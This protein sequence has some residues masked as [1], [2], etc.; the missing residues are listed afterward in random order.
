MGA[1]TGTPCTHEECRYL[2]GHGSPVCFCGGVWHAVASNWD[3]YSFGHG[4][5]HGIP[6]CVPE[7]QKHRYRTCPWSEVV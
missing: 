4:G 7:V 2:R 6:D 3:A 1:H 5:G